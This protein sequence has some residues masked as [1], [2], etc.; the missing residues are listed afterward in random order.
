MSGHHV[1]RRAC[2]SRARR[3]PPGRNC[4]PRKKHGRDRTLAGGAGRIGKLIFV[5]RS[6]IHAHRFMRPLYLHHRAPKLKTALRPWNFKQLAPTGHMFFDLAPQELKLHQ[7]KDHG[8]LSR[9]LYFQSLTPPKPKSAKQKLRSND[10]F[11]TSGFDKF[12]QE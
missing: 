2:C 4:G 1:G 7:S 6:H 5:S 3:T 11:L 10:F 9:F 12:F 8:E